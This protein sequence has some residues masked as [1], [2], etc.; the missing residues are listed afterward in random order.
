MS[1]VRIYQDRHHRYLALLSEKEEK[2]ATQLLRLQEW[3]IVP[4]FTSKTYDNAEKKIRYLSGTYD[5][6]WVVG[7][8][9]VGI[10]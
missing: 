10:G 9:S 4:G 1:I 6:R 2:K 3:D 8:V 7:W 5:R